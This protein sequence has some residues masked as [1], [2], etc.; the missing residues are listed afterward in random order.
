MIF[1]AFFQASQRGERLFVLLAV[2]LQLGLR[3]QDRI[4]R[5]GSFF[6]GELEPLVTARVL[7]LQVGCTGG[8][9][10]VEQGCVALARRARKEFLAAREVAFG[11][12]DHAARKS[13]AGASGTETAGRFAEPARRLH[14]SPYEPHGREQRANEHDEHGHGHFEQVSAETNRNVTGIAEQEVRGYRTQDQ[15]DDD[16]AGKFHCVGSVSVWYWRSRRS[17]CEISGLATATD[18]SRISLIVLMAPATCV[19]ST[20]K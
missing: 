3:K 20:S 2:E 18:A 11:Y 19:L 13:C 10:V 12:L 8:L 1:R 17:D 6:E 14:E 4:R 7:P 9:Q 5:L 15:R 16:D